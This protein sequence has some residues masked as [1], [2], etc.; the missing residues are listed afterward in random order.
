MAAVRRGKTLNSRTRLSTLLLRSRL[1]PR[2]RGFPNVETMFL[3]KKLLGHLLMPLPL[4]LVLLSLALWASA[5]RRRGAAWT[6]LLFGWLILVACG[7]R[8]V[9][10]ALVASLENH[11]KPVPPRPLPA[12]PAAL[13]ED[14]P[15]AAA[16]EGTAWPRELLEAGFVAVLGGGH[17]DAEGLSAGQRLSPS[18]RA[19]LVEGVRLALALPET[20]LVVSGPRDGARDGSPAEGEAPPPSHARVLADAAVEL[21][22]PRDR[23][24]EIDTA[25]DTA[26]EVAALRRLVGEEKTALVTSA[27]HLPR[28][29]KLAG[30]EG[31][32]AFPC[33]SDYLGG[34]DKP[35]GALA[36]ATW[37]SESLT[38]STRAWREYLGHAWAGLVAWW[39]R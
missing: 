31:L 38:N 29:M 9:S 10:N 22:L 17:G 13:P 35:G 28:A 2:N 20:W 6:A 3:L 1:L 23:I 7:N 24:V 16:P 26:E 33:P 37:N 14:G 34:R 21:G 11:Y 18:A 32:D 30:R 19:R 36:W 4:A 8:G 27:W 12:G 15:D 5:R 25:R 39:R